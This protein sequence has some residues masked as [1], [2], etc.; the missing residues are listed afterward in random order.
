MP[1]VEHYAQRLLSPFRGS[2]HTIK[3]EAAEAVTLDGVHWDIYVSN[4]FL[5]EGLDVSRWTQI[6]DIRFG[7]W[8]LQQGLKRG[9]I[10]P[11]DDFLR[12]EEMG[13]IVYQ[14]LTQIHDKVPFPFRDHYELWLLDTEGLPLALLSSAI[15]EKEIDLE[16]APQ[17]RAGY[18]AGDHFKSAVVRDGEPAADYLTR[19]I[20]A[21]AGREPCAQ[22]FRRTADGSGIGLD[23]IELP[24]AFENRTLPADAFPLL[25]LATTANDD[26]HRQLIADFHA[27]QAPWLLSL[28]YLNQEMRRAL[29]QQARK[30]AHVVQK[31]HRLYPALGDAGTIKAALVE[32]VMLNAHDSA[33]QSRDN[34]MSTFYIELN[35]TAQDWDRGK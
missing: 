12:M 26:R 28:P 16:L 23:G 4:D 25:L 14:H 7:S 1:A 6:T 3:Y 34:T 32:A 29:E 27:W 31:L 13:A 21:C 9:P 5:L 22:W 15:S 17:W 8:S 24:L 2:M 30:Q 19:H 10:Y 11:S 35:N 18:V 20:N 33:T